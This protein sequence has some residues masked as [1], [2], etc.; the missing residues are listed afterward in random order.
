MSG[1]D[2]KHTSM[3]YLYLFLWMAAMVPLTRVT[4]LHQGL[5]VLVHF[6]PEHSP[7]KLLHHHV[8]AQVS[9]MCKIEDVFPFKLRDHNVHI[10]F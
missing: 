1:P 4:L 9:P 2:I 7:S 6:V 10:V 5:H 3:T 8:L